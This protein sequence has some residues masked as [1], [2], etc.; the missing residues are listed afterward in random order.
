MI[1]AQLK[2]VLRILIVPFIFSKCIVSCVLVTQKCILFWYLIGSIATLLTSISLLYSLYVIFKAHT[3]SHVLSFSHLGDNPNTITNFKAALEELSN[4]TSFVCVQDSTF[5]FFKNE[6]SLSSLMLYLVI[7]D[8]DKDTDQIIERFENLSALGS[9]PRHKKILLFEELGFDLFYEESYLKQALL[10]FMHDID[11]DIFVPLYHNRV[12]AG[13]FKV[14]RGSRGLRPYTF[15]EQNGMITFASYVGNIIGMMHNNAIEHIRIR[16]A[17]LNNDLYLKNREIN[18]YK[19]CIQSFF[20]EKQNPLHALIVYKHNKFTLFNEHARTLCQVEGSYIGANHPV[21][22][23][24]QTIMHHLITL[25][26]PVYR[27]L[28]TLLPETFIMTAIRNSNEEIVIIIN[29][30]D[31]ADLLEHQSLT[32]T[33][34]Y[35]ILYLMYLQSSSSGRQISSV[36]PS[37]GPSILSSKL[38]LFKKML[39][40]DVLF[41]DA[42]PSDVGVVAHLIAQEHVTKSIFIIEAEEFSNENITKTNRTIPLLNKFNKQGI[43]VIKDLQQVNMNAQYALAKFIAQGAGIFDDRN[44]YKNINRSRLLFSGNKNLSVLNHEQRVHPVL[45]RQLKGRVCTIPTPDQLDATEL[46]KLIDGFVEQLSPERTTAVLNEFDKNKL[47][48]EHYS[49]IK[50]LYLATDRLVKQHTHYRKSTIYPSDVGQHFNTARTIYFDH[51]TL[52][53]PDALINL[54]TKLGSYYKV[55]HMLGVHP[56]SVYRRLK[57]LGF[58]AG[59]QEHTSL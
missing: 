12:L 24:C 29:K 19:K 33:I 50:D 2:S 31:I 27:H 46:H 52:K 59:K 6:F 7:K 44:M 30:A 15:E 3:W 8:A 55:A 5:K 56:S 43:F 4:I 14:Q 13:Y 34:P 51:Q 58:F 10:Q 21:A 57:N 18:I 35:D 26:V 17:G 9:L 54:F 22:Q 1:S 16:K 38:E 53:D 32:G 40:R 36:L 37:F 28:H 41:L 25:E 39:E 42:H 48:A 20:E 49:S 47:I 45:F 23:A 11:A